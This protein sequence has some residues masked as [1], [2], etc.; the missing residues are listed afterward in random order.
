M[1]ISVRI[2]LASLIV[3]AAL[4]CS[5]PTMPTPNTVSAKSA[6]HQERDTAR[7][8][9]DLI[10]PPSKNRYKTIR[11]LD[12]W[13]NPYL[14]VQGEMLTLHITRPDA[15]PSN[16]GVGT[17][18]RPASAR[19]ETINVNPAD[20]ATALTAIPQDAWPYGRVIAV[21]EAHN[22]PV[23][24]RPQVRRNM[25]AAMTTLTDLGIIVDEWTDQGPAT[26]R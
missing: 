18:L 15:N 19:R 12:G 24:A 17:I 22:T 25:E 21:E 26:L 2:L 1:V 23:K 7:A 9:L 8:Q 14:T 6:S 10:P 3:T 20:L 5:A 11:T 16:L 4:G 13:E